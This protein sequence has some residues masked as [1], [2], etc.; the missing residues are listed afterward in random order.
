MINGDKVFLASIILSFVVGAILL[1]VGSP[2]FGI[3][4]IIVGA[5]LLYL[6]HL[7]GKMQKKQEQ[8]Y[9]NQR[10]VQEKKN[11]EIAEGKWDFPSKD[12]YSQCRAAGIM[13]L[14]AAYSQAKAKAI[15][16]AILK[17]NDIPEHY[18]PLYDSKEKISKY[19]TAG[20]IAAAKESE[21]QERAKRV[22]QKAQISPEQE[23]LISFYSEL[24]ERKGKEKRNAM[25]DSIIASYS[26]RIES[27]KKAQESMQKMAVMMA[28]SAAQKKTTSWAT[29]AGIANGIAGPVAG[30]LAGAETMQRNA[31][32]E[33][34][35]RRNREKVNKA[36]AGIMNG[37]F[38]LSSDIS[39]LTKER[40]VFEQAKRD[41]EAKVALEDIPT[42][43]LFD[44][45]SISNVKVTKEKNEALTIS[46][47]I[48]SNYAPKEIPSQVK[49]CIDGTLK[50]RVFAGNLFV[51]TVCLPLPL[52][53]VECGTANA[54][55]AETMSEN[56]AINDYPYRV[57]WEPNKLW[58]MEV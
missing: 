38:S 16:D 40:E 47:A 58:L 12:F 51:G 2:L 27:V 21:E 8:F 56:Y 29:A 34:Q 42:R 3:I 6:W 55:R 33:A 5:V 53:G 1:I 22:P 17:K 35:N 26:E 43:E 48:M 30:A 32:I 41:L 9:E 19:L 39:S 37:S 10:K 49:M 57:V 4:L 25:L 18:Y 7:G 15:A 11:Q 44:S 46:A 45:L 50:G 31:E 52:F 14:E 28:S 36:A 54:T 24:A 20:L 23:K 13:T